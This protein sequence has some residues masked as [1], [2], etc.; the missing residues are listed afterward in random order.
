[1]HRPGFHQLWWCRRNQ[2]TF[3]CVDL[4]EANKAV[5]NDSYPL[6]HID[7][8]LSKLYGATVFTKIDLENAYFLTS[9]T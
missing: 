9:T 7:E 4:R 2:E 8:L 3:A 1:M 6:P 5:I